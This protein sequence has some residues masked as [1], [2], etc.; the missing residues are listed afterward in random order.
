VP[1]LYKWAC[2]PRWGF[3][4]RFGGSTPSPQRFEAALWQGVLCQYLVVDGSDR[5][6]AIVV[7]YGADHING[8]AYVAIQGNPSIRTNVGAMVGTVQLVEHLFSHWRFRK[9]HADVPAYNIA[10]F[11]HGFGRYMD[12][13]LTLR[14][15]IYHANRFWDL[16]TYTLSRE[17]WTSIA[18]RFNPIL[19]VPTT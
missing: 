15:H 9:L 12:A 5:R 6:C 8:I 2:D 4:W 18:G 7:A 17:R 19:V 14:D 10:Q 16:V 1:E 3:R 11:G 13:E